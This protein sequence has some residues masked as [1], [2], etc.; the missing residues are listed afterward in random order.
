V[1]TV[2]ELMADA[3]KADDAYADAV[4][5]MAQARADY[6]LAFYT[7]MAKSPDKAVSARKQFA[8]QAAAE[9]HRAF[10]LAD[11][12]EQAARTHVRVLL[13]LLVAAQSVQKHAGKQDGGTDWGEGW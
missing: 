4:R 1:R 5:D 6:E 12:Q 13:G 3:E 9:Q 10:L 2:S 11:A 8:E 7:A